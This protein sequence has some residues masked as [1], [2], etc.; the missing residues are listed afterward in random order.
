MT[1]STIKYNVNLECEYSE[2]EG[3]KVISLPID[4]IFQSVPTAEIVNGKP[5]YQTIKD[6]IQT[7]G[8]H[9]PIMVVSVRYWQL[10]ERYSL[11]R[12]TMLPPPSGF[13]NNELI[14]VVWGG[15]NRLAAARSLGYSHIDCVI[16]PNFDEAWSK[17]SLHRLP[18]K[19]LYGDKK[20]Q[21]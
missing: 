6:D 10:L 12:D 3:Y 21:K 16:M 5:F 11:H 9:F 1:E 18:Y 19:H 13:T 17:Q 20:C 2:W 14:H 7:N 8:L 15:S 4:N